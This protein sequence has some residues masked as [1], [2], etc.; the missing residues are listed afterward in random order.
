MCVCVFFGCVYNI[1]IYIYT[2]YGES[3]KC[4]CDFF[5]IILRIL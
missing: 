3:F 5:K 1:Y 4:V 2:I